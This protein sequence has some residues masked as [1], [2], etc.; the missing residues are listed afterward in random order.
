MKTLITI[1]SLLL[2]LSIYAQPP[3]MQPV[4]NG[5]YADDTE[6]TIADWFVFMYSVAN[7]ETEYGD[8]D[9]PSINPM[10][11]TSLL[12]D[13]FLPVFRNA[14]LSINKDYEGPEVNTTHIYSE[15]SKSSAVFAAPKAAVIPPNVWEYPIVGI[16][17]E[18][19][20]AYVIWRN[21]KLL[22]DKKEKGKWT[23]FLPDA[24][25]WENIARS[26]YALSVSKAKDQAIKNE[27]KKIYEVD[28][29]NSK[30]CLLMAI[31]N[32]TPCEN[33][34]KY[35]VKAKGGIFPAFSFFPNQYGLCC[36]HGNV[37]EMTSKNGIAVGGNFQLTAAD[38]RF[39][40]KQ[41]YQKPE[42]W[43]GFRCVAVRKKT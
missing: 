10:P 15:R 12:N 4:N 27:L 2:S 7:E 18:Q 38:A 14:E 5:L 22:A 11:D 31:R 40:S 42:G 6:I 39:D 19:A 28:G 17:F 16:S 34:K 23:V 30:G 41:T 32:D 13:Y 3:G 1:L 26:A 36:M 37:S 8:V 9:F 43:L 29:R 33:D 20:K 35:L 21:A 24:A 25:E